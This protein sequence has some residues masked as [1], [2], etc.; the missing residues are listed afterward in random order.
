MAKSNKKLSDGLTQTLPDRPLCYFT[1]S[2]T[3]LL[4]KG[5]PLGGKGLIVPTCPT[6]FL[7]P[8]SPR[9]VKTVPFVSLLCLTLYD[10][11]H[12]GRSSGWERVNAG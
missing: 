7:N 10:F 1:L 5:E 2:K 9:P 11:M 6:L 12:Q 8:F 4:V 3:I